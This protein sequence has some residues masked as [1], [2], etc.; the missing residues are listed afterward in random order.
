MSHF[1]ISQTHHFKPLQNSVFCL[2]PSHFLYSPTG[3]KNLK[4][5]MKPKIRDGARKSRPK[6]E[7]DATFYHQRSITEENSFKKKKFA[8]HS[9]TQLNHVCPVSTYKD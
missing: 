9:H 6:T 5:G 2:L 4:S 3:P 8:E 7:L 1:A